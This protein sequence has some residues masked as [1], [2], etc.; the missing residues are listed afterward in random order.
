MPPE[1]QRSKALLAR[2]LRS[3]REASGLTQAQVA[4]KLRLHRPAIAEIE[5]GR[6]NVGAYELKLMADLYAVSISWLTATKEDELDLSSDHL[7]L[8][9]RELS[10]LKDEDLDRLVKLLHLL[11]KS[12]TKP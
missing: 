7:L 11:R 12:G 1:D 10:K 9:A 5:A 4:K 6:R 8:A 2:R 3:A